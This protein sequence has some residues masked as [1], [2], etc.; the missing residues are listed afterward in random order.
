[1]VR[2]SLYG[3][4]RICLDACI[5][6]SG[7]V[8]ERV[9]IGIYHCDNNP[10]VSYIHL[11]RKRPCYTT[12][13][14]KCANSMCEIQCATGRLATHP[15]A[16]LTDSKMLHTIF[17]AWLSSGLRFSALPPLAGS[18]CQSGA[19]RGEVHT[20]LF[21]S[22][23]LVCKHN[24]TYTT[25]GGTKQSWFQQR[26]RTSNDVLHSNRSRTA[27]PMAERRYGMA[28]IFMY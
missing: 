21:D 19:G 17:V 7:C 28:I 22:E 12:Q 4:V 15:G 20:G 3:Y 23:S 14:A 9:C 1:M 11:R 5:Q 18:S 8:N 6:A 25:H 16:L 2:N 26:Q 10:N 13:R 24:A 27:L